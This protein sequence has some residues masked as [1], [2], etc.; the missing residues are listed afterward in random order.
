MTVATMNQLYAFPTIPVKHVLRRDVSNVSNATQLPEEL[1]PS[2]VEF[3]SDSITSTSRSFSSYLTNLWWNDI[4]P[5]ISD[6]SFEY[7]EAVSEHSTAAITPSQALQD[8]LMSLV[9]IARSEDFDDSLEGDFAKGLS[10]IIGDHQKITLD[11]IYQWIV[12]DR[13]DRSSA[14]EAVILI[15][16][17]DTVE[18]RHIR[19]EFLLRC[20]KAESVRIRY[21]AILGLAYLNDPKSLEGVKAAIEDEQIASMKRD[22]HQLIAQLEKTAS[23]IR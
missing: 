23:E 5:T 8:Q 17:F 2:E 15:G 12:S 21:A 18:F 3:E 14:S 6:Q 7:I 1:S 20:L 19:R 16:R 11:L 9:S 10:R 13:I 22:I 4:V